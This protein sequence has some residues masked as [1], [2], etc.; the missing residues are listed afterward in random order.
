MAYNIITGKES[1]EETKKAKK[2]PSLYCG[3]GEVQVGRPSTKVCRPPGG[4]SNIFFESDN[5]DNSRSG[6]KKQE[7]EQKSLV[8]T[9]PEQIED[10]TDS[11]VSTDKSSKQ[12]S[13]LICNEGSQLQNKPSIRV[14]HPPGGGHSSI[15]F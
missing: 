2:D 14:R 10:S 7:F 6:N 13:T 1:K 15:T 12:D 4:A 9:E 5:V 11:K 8:S 3:E